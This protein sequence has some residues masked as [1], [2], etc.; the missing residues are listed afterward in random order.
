MYVTMKVNMSKVN[1]I[2]FSLINP[3]DLRK[4]TKLHTVHFKGNP[5]F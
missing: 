4:K 2:Y 5:N 3:K 1:L